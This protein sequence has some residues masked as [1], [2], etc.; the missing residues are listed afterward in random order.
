V[1]DNLFRN[2]LCAEAIRLGRVLVELV[3]KVPDLK[4]NPEL[5]GLLALMLLHDARRNARQGPQGELRVLEEQDR[6]R[7]KQAQIAEGEALL[8]R[9]LAQR[10]PGPYQIQAAISALHCQA[11]T[12]AETDW[13][14]IA[15]LYSEL[16]RLTR[17]PVVRLNWAIAVAMATTPRRGLDLLDQLENDPN[18]QNYYLFHAARADLLRRS[19]AW[20]P[21][22]QS[23]RQALSLT[24]NSVER[25]FLER[26]LNE[27]AARQKPALTN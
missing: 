11:A 10:R 23:Y 16:V 9:A 20:E 21:A 13:F 24:H 2:E 25:A 7:W 4:E 17:S 15:L 14:Q 26:R 22:R 12:H 6:S 1:G 5:L 19:E 27:I 18:L 8:E 3:F